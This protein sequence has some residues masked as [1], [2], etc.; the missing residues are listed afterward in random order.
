MEYAKG[1]LFDIL[2][3]FI[4][5]AVASLLM[6][7]AC[8]H[9]CRSKVTAH[10]TVQHGH[11]AQWCQLIPPWCHQALPWCHLI[12][13]WCQLVLVWCQLILPWCHRILPWTEWP[14]RWWLPPRHRV[15]RLSCSSR[16]SVKTRT[17]STAP[18]LSRSPVDPTASCIT[19][20]KVFNSVSQGNCCIIY[21][22]KFIE[23]NKALGTY[24]CMVSRHLFFKLSS[25]AL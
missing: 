20:G 13:P 23:V 18:Q 25:K 22:L 24:N 16:C 8:S 10:A 5:F 6:L 4:F 19:A 1:A 3:M 2:Y 14:P 15:R 9:L 21:T 7:C 11:Q 17:S 12:P